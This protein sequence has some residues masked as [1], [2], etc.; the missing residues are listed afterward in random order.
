MAQKLWSLPK[1]NPKTFDFD[2][3]GAPKKKRAHLT[4]KERVYVWEH[5]QIYG[6]K[7][8]ICGGRITRISDL[9]LDHTRA[10]SKGGTT[11]R[12]AH[13]D[14]NRLKGSK[15]L[16]H[17]QKKMTFKRTKRKVKRTKK[18]TTGPAGLFDFKPPKPMKLSW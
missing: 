15:G 3:A 5:P 4:A 8:S 9:E 11:M 14:C 7:C 2:T 18:R 1:F 13:R 6:R 10:Y 16:V 17:I 12:L